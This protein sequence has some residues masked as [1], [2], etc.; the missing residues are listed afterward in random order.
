V[1][2]H[3]LES[4]MLWHRL[5][6]WPGRVDKRL[7]CSTVQDRPPLP[8]PPPMCSRDN[9]WYADTVPPSCPVTLPGSRLHVRC[10]AVEEK[11]Q[12]LTA[13]AKVRAACPAA[14]SGM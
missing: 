13:P 2:V 11:Q 1:C 12:T 3:G 5:L 14:C 6:G 8:P 7:V 10:E 9:R 4:R